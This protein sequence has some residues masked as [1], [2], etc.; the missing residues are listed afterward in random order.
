MIS[1][2]S[3]LLLE[4]LGPFSGRMINAQDLD[5][6]PLDTIRNAIRYAVNDE[7]VC[8]P[9]SSFPPHLG[10]IPQLIYRDANV[11]RDLECHTWIV[12][13]GVFLKCEQSFR[14]RRRPTNVH[15]QA[16]LYLS[17][18]TSISASETNRP[19]SPALMPSLIRSSCQASRSRY[20]SIAWFTT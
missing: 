11:L 2:D 13:R 7:F 15:D 9:H 17:N 6:F 10:M 8:T 5:L 16:S 18:I 19:A 20:R 3:A 14:S 4:R 1:I 12:T